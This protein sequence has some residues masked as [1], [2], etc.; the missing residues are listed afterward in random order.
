MAVEN[1]NTWVCVNCNTASMSFAEMKTHL[2]EVHKLDMAGL[3]GSK[4]M[5]MHMDGKDWF[6]GVDEWTFGEL[7]LE[8]S[9][10]IK[11]TKKTGLGLF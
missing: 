2:A 7:T 3:Q 5:K 1:S 8:Q 10:R 9:Y 11:R 4:R 6:S